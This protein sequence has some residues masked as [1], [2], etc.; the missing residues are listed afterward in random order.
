MP[1]TYSFHQDPLAFVLLRASGAI[2]LV[3]WANAMEQVIAD[4]AFRET[5][6]IVLDLSAA[7]GAELQPDETVT[8]AWTWRLMTPRSRGAIIASQ[9]ALLGV[10][11]RVEQ[12]SAGE[13]GSFS[14]LEAAVQWLTASPSGERSMGVS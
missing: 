6:P 4:G 8:L 2:H 10:A 5:M 14:E 3:T 9:G 1:F 13:V 7:T 12:Q 11:R